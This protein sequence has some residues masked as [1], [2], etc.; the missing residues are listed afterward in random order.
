MRKVDGVDRQNGDMNPAFHCSPSW[1]SLLMA[2]AIVGAWNNDIVDNIY[3]LIGTVV[4]IHVQNAVGPNR[5]FL[6]CAVNVPQFN[7]HID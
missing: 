1:H 7:E 4:H 3:S 6:I 2:L 5:L